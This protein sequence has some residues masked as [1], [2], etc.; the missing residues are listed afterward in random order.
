MTAGCIKK[1]EDENIIYEGIELNKKYNIEQKFY[2]INI[3]SFSLELNY[4]GYIQIII[5]SE[6]KNYIFYRRNIKKEYFYLNK[7]NNCIL[8]FDQ[9]GSF[10]VSE[11]NIENNYTKIDSTF[12]NLQYFQF[13]ISEDLIHL[14]T[15]FKLSYN[16][17][18]YQEN[19]KK[20]IIFG[21]YNPIDIECLKIIPQTAILWGGS[22]IMLPSRNRNKA[23]KIIK[24]K[25]IPNF[26]MS[27]YIYDKLIKLGITN[28]IKVNI[29]FCWNDINYLQYNSL[30]KRKKIFIYDGMNKCK[31]K[32]NIYNQDLID[33][34]CANKKNTIRTS[35]KYIDNIYN[36]YKNCFISLRLT[37]Y[38]GNANSA[39]EC[40]MFSI[41][42]ISN[43]EMNHC[44]SWKT[45]EE[46]NHKVKYVNK[47]NIKIKWQKDGINLL[48]FSNDDIN[49]GGGSTF[50][51]YLTNYL[52]NRGFNIK[53]IYWIHS[54]KEYIEKTDN[55]IK[56]F[57][58]HNKKWN[59]NEKLKKLQLFNY[60]IILR[61][62][63]PIRE[64]NILEENYEILFFTPGLFKNNLNKKFYNI[65]SDVEKYL[66]KSNLKIA[67]KCRTYCN[68]TL[69]QSLYQ[70]YGFNKTE[71]LE[72]N[73]L[74]INDEYF[75][76][77]DRNINI[78]FVV[79]DIQREIKNFKL[80]LELSEKINNCVLISANKITKT[81]ENIKIIEN[82][83][84]IEDYY[85]NAKILLN[86][87]FFDSMSNTV[88][89]GIN[90]GCHILVS[91]CN[92][93]CSYIDKEF[94]IN[95]KDLIQQ[96]KNIL[97]NFNNLESNRKDL[98]KKLQEKK[99]E[100]EIQILDLLSR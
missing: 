5:P 43:Q 77:K 81:F 27:N 61:S 93:I 48:F 53:T 51:F 20:T 89:E 25:N 44:I 74:Q 4:N 29:S 85:R 67:D 75:S 30:K 97:D 90:N 26:A 59:I 14:K 24:E 49:F 21:I 80:F 92:G 46:I 100:V 78:L 56:I 91:D 62:Y 76:K 72:I 15:K 18:Y 39:Q 95:E 36:I 12:N 86:C 96:C 87:S 73:F 88:L 82:P 99:W 16:L 10:S 19:N 8:Y 22:D 41:P 58:N 35:N 38:D 98:I 40:G 28:I 7:K 23:I 83:D 64:Y 65:Q 68:S 47:N 3:K 50:T 32:N 33:K 2:V 13:L 70:R 52:K 54:E 66:N 84:N 60:K 94:I 71:L 6:R 37:N 63:I 17:D 31:K 45:I 42:V 34:F 11:E 55:I 1:I 69:T 9:K 79:S 57:L